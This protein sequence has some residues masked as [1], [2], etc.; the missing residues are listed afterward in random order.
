MWL[1]ALYAASSGYQAF[2]HPPLQSPPMVSVEVE[3][4]MAAD[5]HKGID[6]RL[7]ADTRGRLSKVFN[8]TSYVLLKHQQASTPCGQAVAFNLP[9]GRILH[10]APMAIE[11]DMIA[12]ELMLFEGVRSVMHTDIKMMK[13]GAIMIVGPRYPQQTYITTIEA[14]EISG[15][16]PAIQAGAP[17]Q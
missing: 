1:A 13:S 12:M 10:V 17:A 14:S 6:P 11:G 5:T 2:A 7:G 15:N 4:L 9:G 8:Y 16:T 3:S